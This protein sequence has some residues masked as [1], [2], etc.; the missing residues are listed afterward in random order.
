MLASRGW[1]IRHGPSSNALYLCFQLRK[2]NP[3]TCDPVRA[4]GLHCGSSF[5]VWIPVTDFG[6]VH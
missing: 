5:P 2:F 3:K 1:V 6:A 4:T